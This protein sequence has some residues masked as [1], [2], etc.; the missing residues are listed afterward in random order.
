MTHIFVSK[1]G[2]H[3]FSHYMNQCGVIVIWVC[4]TKLQ[5]ALNLNTI[6]FVQKSI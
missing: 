1:L 2:H 5:L 6:T 3:W 4:A